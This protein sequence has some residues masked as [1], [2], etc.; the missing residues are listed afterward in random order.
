MCAR[1]NCIDGLLLPWQIMSRAMQKLWLVATARLY[2]K[3]KKEGAL[4][5][6]SFPGKTGD[7][8]HSLVRSQTTG[9]NPDTE[10][11]TRNRKDQSRLNSTSQMIILDAVGALACIHT[12]SNTTGAEQLLL[13]PTIILC[14]SVPKTRKRGQR[15][16]RFFPSSP[17]TNVSLTKGHICVKW[18]S[19]ESKSI[20]VLCTISGRERE[21]E[22]GAG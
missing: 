8:I 17:S 11:T 14:A 12:H 15:P 7:C 18:K 21:R 1:Q 19:I 22:H 13:I 20:T 10:H 16:A 5:C 6:L 9:G 4:L 2:E 3:G